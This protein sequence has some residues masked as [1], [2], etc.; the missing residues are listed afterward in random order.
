ML[1]MAYRGGKAHGLIIDKMN[2]IE[3]LEVELAMGWQDQK[4]SLVELNYCKVAK[5]SEKP[6][7]SYQT[8]FILLI[9]SAI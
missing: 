6:Y 3:T 4:F 9:L 5:T 7:R 1:K 2:Q 8:I